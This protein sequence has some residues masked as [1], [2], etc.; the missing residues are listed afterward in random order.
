[1]LVKQLCNAIVQVQLEGITSLDLCSCRHEFCENTDP[2][3]ILEEDS[4]DGE[5]NI[6]DEQGENDE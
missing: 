3:K 5:D 2:K 1:M 6:D 4:S